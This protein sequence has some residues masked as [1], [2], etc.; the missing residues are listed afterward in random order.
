M[1]RHASAICAAPSAD[2]DGWLFKCARVLVCVC[3]CVWMRAEKLVLNEDAYCMGRIGRI[4]YTRPFVYRLYIGKLI[5]A[6]PLI[7]STRALEH[8]G[9]PRVEST[10]VYNVYSIETLRDKGYSARPR[11]ALIISSRSSFSLS[12]RA[13][14]ILWESGAS[15][16]KFAK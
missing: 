2:P 15:W 10:Y 6:G 1:L 7:S 14:E 16:L 4:G 9:G 3:V 5:G 13:R 8:P 11:G 12:P